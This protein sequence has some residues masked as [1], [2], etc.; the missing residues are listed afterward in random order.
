MVRSTLLQLGSRGAL[1]AIL[2]GP[3]AVL[4]FTFNPTCVASKS[5]PET[6][7]ELSQGFQTMRNPMVSM[8][9]PGDHGNSP[10]ETDFG[11]I[12]CRF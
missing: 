3:P 6:K 12:F 9:F 8:I 4:F 7:V 2:G 11:V 5:P 1:R 10:P